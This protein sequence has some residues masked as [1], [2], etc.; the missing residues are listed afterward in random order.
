MASWFR[1]DDTS[2]NDGNY[3]IEDAIE[4]DGAGG[5][6]LI[7][8]D[9]THSEIRAVIEGNFKASADYGEDEDEDGNLDSDEDEDDDDEWDEFF[10]D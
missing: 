4:P 9:D 1:F 6:E 2:T 8:G 10:Q 7:L 3:S 5:Y